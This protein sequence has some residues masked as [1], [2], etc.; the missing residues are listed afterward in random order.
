MPVRKPE[1][2]SLIGSKLI[3]SSMRGQADC[4]GSSSSACREPMTLI[5]LVSLCFDFR[6]RS[7]AVPPASSSHVARERPN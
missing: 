7:P 3:V 5:A 2:A 4:A 6:E 1:C